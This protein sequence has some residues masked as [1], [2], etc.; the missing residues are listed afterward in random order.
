MDRR[1]ALVAV[2]GTGGIQQALDWLAEH[3]DDD[4]E[5]GEQVQDANDLDVVDNEAKSLCCNECGKLFSSVELA[6]LHAARLGHQDFSESTEVNPILT[7]EQKAQRLEELK[8][9]LAEKR[10]L[11]ARQAEEEAHE[12]EKIRRKGGMM[13]ADA[14]RELKEKEMIKAAEQM[15]KERAEDKAI[16]ARIRAEMEEE[17]RLKKE[18]LKRDPSIEEPVKPVEIAL[19]SQDSDSVRIQVKLPEG[20]NLRAVFKSNEI[21]ADLVTKLREK[22]PVSDGNNLIV[23][24]PRKVINIGTEMNKTFVELGLCPSASLVLE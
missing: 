24:F 13:T 8:E 18:A 9:K 7:K 15:R 23:P 5:L 2:G 10:R 17:K 16:L 19:V 1:R 20:D 11:E 12:A 14:K 4:N 3:Q 22:G 6:Q 21:L